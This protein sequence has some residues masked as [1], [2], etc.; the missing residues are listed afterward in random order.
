MRIVPI[1][2]KN[3]RLGKKYPASKAMGGKRYKKNKSTL[4]I[5]V[6]LNFLNNL[7]GSRY[8]SCGRTKSNKV[9]TKKPAT[10]KSP[11]SGNIITSRSLAWN[12]KILF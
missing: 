10:I 4:N 11:E 5:F 6:R 3:A 12:T 2:R 1:L 8:I 9:P 7:P